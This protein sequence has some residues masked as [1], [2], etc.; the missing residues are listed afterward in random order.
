MS[1]LDSELSDY[2][3]VY[4]LDNPETSAYGWVQHKGTN[5]CI[6]MHCIC[7]AHG[8][9]DDEF[10]YSVQCDDCGRKYAVGQ[11]IKLIPLDTPELIRASEKYHADYKHF[12][13]EY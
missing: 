9:I 4:S 10:V 5:L 3:K 2:D 1:N 11:K 7:G 6:D 13:E 8:H 12:I